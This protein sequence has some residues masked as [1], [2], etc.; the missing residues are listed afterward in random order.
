MSKDSTESNNPRKLPS[1]ESLREALRIFRY[2]TPYKWYFI[3]GLILLALSSGVFMLFPFL[4]GLMIDT[5]QGEETTLALDMTQ[6]GWLIVSILVIQG[7]VSYFRVILFAHSS[8]KGIADIRRALYDKMITLPYV[9]YEENRIGE[10]LSRITADVE[11]M[12]SAFSVTLAEFIRQ[13]IIVVVGI[14]F[15]M[16]TTPKLALIMLLSF[17]VIV[18]IAFFFG[19]KI[20]KLSRKRQ[21]ALADTNTIMNETIQSIQAVKSFTNE[22]YETRRYSN[23]I[24][25]VVHIALDFAQKRALFAAF[26]VSVLFGALLFVIWQGSVMVQN[27]TVTAGQLVSFVTYTM[28][29]GGSIAGLGSFYTEILG[30]VGATE[31]VREILDEHGELD[32]DSPIEPMRLS[33]KIQFEDVHFKYPT[34][35]DIDVLKGINLEVLPGQSVA[36]VGSSGAGKSTIMQLLLRFYNIESGNIALDGRN[37]H[38][39]D[40]KSYRSHFSIVPQ[41]VILFGGSIRENILY[42]KPDASEAEVIEAAERSNSW[43]FIQSFPEGLDTMVGE[44]GVKLSGGQRQ[45]IAIARAILKNPTVLLLDE[46]TSSL[47]SESEKAVQE[48]LDNLME[49]RTSIVVAHRLATIK[50]VDKIYVLDNGIISEQGTHEELYSKEN[51]LYRNLAKHQFELV[52]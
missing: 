35:P 19:R 45:R 49:N 27:G 7:V 2:M 33:G 48:A 47:D 17:P 13:V 37:I 11:K 46:A 25:D 41:E 3:G 28:I 39:Y 40:L 16:I 51:G 15:L 5:A 31:R 8:E 50:N 18:I 4:I 34:R 10:L 42:G 29:I 24:T 6:I 52:G 9:F 43:E 1:K 36:L 26:I 44:R 14:L 22:S 38:D 12:F 32:S 21:N 23:S 30:A 20:R